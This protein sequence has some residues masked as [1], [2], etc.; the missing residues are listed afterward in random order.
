MRILLS[1][2]SLL[3]ILHSCIPRYEKATAVQENRHYVDGRYDSEFPVSPTSKY[4]KQITQTVRLITSLTFYK[5]YAFS[6]EQAITRADI[7]Q[8]SFSVKKTAIQNAISQKPATGTSTLISAEGNKLLFLTCAHIISEPDTLIQ[9]F[10]DLS[11]HPSPFIQSISI[12]IK[13]NINIPST[14]PKTRIQVIHLDKKKD[15]ALIGVILERIPEVPIVP[16]TYPWGHA[17]ELDWGTFVYS[18]GY[19]NGKKMVST[20]IVSSPNRNK[21]HDFLLDATLHRG[22]SGGI[23]LALRDGPPHFELVGIANALSAKEEYILRPD[24][25]ASLTELARNHPYKGDIY[26]DRQLTVIYGIT[27]AISVENIRRFI[28]ESQNKLFQNGFRFK[29]R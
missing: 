19:P 24:P 20:A 12:K 2:L 14:P 1:I 17:S 8:P 6:M 9:Y 21:M 11:G 23:I 22:I 27:F 7:Q 3:F 13:R 26:V 25:G 10:L 15:L 16:F 28:E 18:I 29:I 4:L 5:T